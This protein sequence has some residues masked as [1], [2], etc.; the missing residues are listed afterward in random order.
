MRRRVR[1]A[2]MPET[3][4]TAGLGPNP[5]QQP[6]EGPRGEQLD[7]QRDSLRAFQ[8]GVDQGARDGRQ[9]DDEGDRQP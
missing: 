1:G 7:R 8:H 6:D 4:L 3:S 5:D 2:Q 9:V